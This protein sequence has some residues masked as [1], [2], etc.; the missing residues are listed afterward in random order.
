MTELPL[1][2]VF[3]VLLIISTGALYGFLAIA[4]PLILPLGLPL[5]AAVAALIAYR[6]R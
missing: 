3:L 5:I 6:P 2:I 1:H 4:A